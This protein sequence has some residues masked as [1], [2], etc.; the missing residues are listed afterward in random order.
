VVDERPIDIRSVRANVERM[1][2][3][4]PENGVMVVA[5]PRAGTGIVVQVVDQVR[6]GGVENVSFSVTN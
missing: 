6:L 4:K 1:H 3:E 2:A 5:D